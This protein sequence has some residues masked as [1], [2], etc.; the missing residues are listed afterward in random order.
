MPTASWWYPRLK[1]PFENSVSSTQFDDKPTQHRDLKTPLMAS[2]HTLVTPYLKLA[3][4][5]ANGLAQNALEMQLF[6]SSRNIDIMILSENTLRKT[7]IS[8][9]PITQYSPCRNC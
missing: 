7:A 8:E 3:L 9:F 6:L 2:S 4:W 5:N 1:T